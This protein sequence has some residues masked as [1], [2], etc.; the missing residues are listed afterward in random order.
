MVAALAQ[1]PHTHQVE[2]G[3][4]HCQRAVDQ[5]EPDVETRI[6]FQIEFSGFTRLGSS[7]LQ[8]LKENIPRYRYLR[9]QVTTPSRF[10]NYD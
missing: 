9:E 3:E 8:S 10:S 2:D 1:P 7:A 5:I 4:R 6:L